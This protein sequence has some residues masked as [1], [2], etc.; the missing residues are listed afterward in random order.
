M[1]HPPKVLR[2]KTR[3]PR[4]SQGTMGP[5]DVRFGFWKSGRH[6]L[7]VSHKIL[8]LLD[9]FDLFDLFDVYPLL[10]GLAGP[11]G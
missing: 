1:K 8:D 7:V 11:A 3:M 6:L 2:Q 9:L 4:V 10:S 5:L